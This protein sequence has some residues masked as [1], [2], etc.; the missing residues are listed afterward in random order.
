MLKARE[1]SFSHIRELWGGGYVVD[2][3]LT[4]SRNTSQTNSVYDKSLFIVQ[5]VENMREV[6]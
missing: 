5:I 3:K 1:I 6:N 4:L 2:I